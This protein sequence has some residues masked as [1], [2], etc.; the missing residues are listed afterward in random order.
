MPMPFWKVLGIAPTVSETDIRRAYAARLRVTN[1]EDDAEGF[2][3]LREAYERALQEARFMQMREAGNAQLAAQRDTAEIDEDADEDEFDDLSPG[4]ISLNSAPPVPSM[5]DTPPETATLNPRELER[6]DHEARCQR[7]ATALGQDCPPE[8]RLEA[9]NAV[10]KSPAMLQVDVFAATEGWLTHMLISSRP[11]SDPLFDPAIDF[12][13]WDEERVGIR[14]DGARH[15]LYLRAHIQAEQDAA[16]VLKRIK[17]RRHEFHAAWKETQRPPSQRSWLNKFLALRHTNKVN[18]FLDHLRNR[19]P[20][21]LGSLNPE[22]VA[23]WRGRAPAARRAGQIL[24]VF[25]LFA[26]LA[27]S[28][29]LSPHVSRFFERSSPPRYVV[30]DPDSPEWAGRPPPKLAALPMTEPVKRRVARKNCADAALSTGDIPG[31]RTSVVATADELCKKALAMMPDSL[32]VRQHVGIV[33]LRAGDA[34]A[35]LAHFNTIL[36]SS[37]DDPYALFGRGLV[38][39]IDP[40]GAALGDP[41]DMADA[42]AMNPDVEPYFARFNVIAP[43]LTPSRQKPESRMP[44]P[45]RFMVTT[46][47]EAPTEKANIDSQEIAEHFGLGSETAGTVVLECLIDARGNVGNCHVGSEDPANVGLGEFGLRA[48]SRVRYTPAKVDDEPV[49]GSP[50]TYTLTLN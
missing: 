37:P 7:L 20:I 25:G 18:E 10:V 14:N 43:P 6:R 27:M 48:M 5:A 39:T 12:F 31:S 42:M 29:V 2:K 19:S 1:P 35:A 22:A 50:L 21:L 4:V 24:T 38:S 8:E 26:V 46:G 34:R 41:K 36:K 30:Y 15:I 33:A 45:K 44:K 40:E 49:G 17:D 3:T 11:A 32:L 13:K 28:V 23:W 47:A 16:R 9:Y